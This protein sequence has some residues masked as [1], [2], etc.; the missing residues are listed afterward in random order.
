MTEIEIGSDNVYE[1]LGYANA[2]AMLVK[3]Q[4]A[5]KT[6]DIIKRRKRSQIQAAEVRVAKGR[7]ARAL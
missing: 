2:D 6:G 4:L 1:D 3:A 7:A 5:S